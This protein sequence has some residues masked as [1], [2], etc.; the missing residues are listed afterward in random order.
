M[1]LPMQACHRD[2]IEHNTITCPLCLKCI[3]TEGQKASV[4]RSIDEQVRRQ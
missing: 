4:W 3:L 2:L 1:L